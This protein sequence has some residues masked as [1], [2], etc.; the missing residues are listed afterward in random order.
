MISMRSA[1]S[2]RTRMSSDRPTRRPVCRLVAGFT[3]LEVL[4]ATAVAAV[5]VALLAQMMDGLRRARVS[6]AAAWSMGAGVMIDAAAVASLL[7]DALPAPG[8]RPELAFVGRSNELRFVAV[9]PQAWREA[10]TLRVVMKVEADRADAVRIV[11]E[12]TDVTPRQAQEPFRHVL[13]SNLKAASFVFA[14]RSG[15]ASL[16]EWTDKTRLPGVIWLQA[17]LTD[18][19]AAPVSVAAAPRRQRVASCV[20]DLVSLECRHEG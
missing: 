8:N 20:I 3:L 11:V 16:S 12:L 10:G 13:M 2:W 14:E 4:V 18:P 9:A 1:I 19:G 5:L 7:R 17:S 6:T 15:G